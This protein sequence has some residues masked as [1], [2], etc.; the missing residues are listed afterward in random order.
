VLTKNDV[1]EYIK[2]TIEYPLQALEL[3]DDNLWRYIRK[4][5]LKEFSYLWPDVT[6]MYYNFGDNDNLAGDI[7]NE[8]LFVDPLGQQVI[9]LVEVLQG[10]P[11]SIKGHPIWGNF[12]TSKPEVWVSDVV[13]AGPNFRWGWNTY[14]FEFIHPNIIR[15]GG[16]NP[17]ACSVVYERVHP[18]DLHTIKFS[19]EMWFLRLALADTKIRLGQIRKKF[20]ELST[21]MGNIPISPDIGDEGKTEKESIIETLTM[22]ASNV[23]VDIW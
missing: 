3:D 4:F 10:D 13:N 2:E 8:F 23:V 12:N 5:T 16:T 9:A 11:F 18:D 6:K 20:S 22:R 15:I 14:S 17:G 19:Q 1:L 7:S 21:P